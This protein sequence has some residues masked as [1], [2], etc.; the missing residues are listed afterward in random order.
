MSC[1]THGGG[2]D[3]VLA[4]ALSALTKLQRA[5]DACSSGGL[6]KVDSTCTGT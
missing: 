6:V 1:L 3:L 2:G 5:K 4:G